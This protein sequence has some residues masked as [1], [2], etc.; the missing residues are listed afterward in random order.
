MEMV[1]KNNGDGV[2][3][4][5]VEQVLRREDE[6]TLAA[7]L[8]ADVAV[9]AHTACSFRVQ[10]PGLKKRANLMY[11]GRLPWPPFSI[12]RAFS[13][14]PRGNSLAQAL[15]AKYAMRTM[16]VPEMVTLV[17]LN[18]SGQGQNYESRTRDHHSRGKETH[19]S[20]SGT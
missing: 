2:Q 15:P 14:S 19:I 12:H 3:R 10:G 8:E 6:Q 18:Y 7:A 9:M 13:L 5:V 11:L 20:R 17:G 16:K 1:L 4:Q